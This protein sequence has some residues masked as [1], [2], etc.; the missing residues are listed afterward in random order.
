MPAFLSL[1][2]P[3]TQWRIWGGSSHPEDRPTEM[4]IRRFKEELGST[5]NEEELIAMRNRL[6]MQSWGKVI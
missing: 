6:G 3:M 2:R 4:H 1:E 5:R